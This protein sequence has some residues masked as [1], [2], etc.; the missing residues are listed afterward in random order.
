MHHAHELILCHRGNLIVQP[1]QHA[2]FNRHR[3]VVLH[4][5]RFDP[6]LRQRLSAVNL[7]EE[8]PVIAEFLR[9]QQPDGGN[10]SWH[11]LHLTNRLSAFPILDLELT[12]TSSV[13]SRIL[14][15]N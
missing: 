4:K 7:R 15:S 11:D 8:P 6:H 10:F 1:A 14:D 12:S 5:V 9:Q 3:M 2:L 13:E